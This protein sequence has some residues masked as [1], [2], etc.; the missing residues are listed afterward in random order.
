VSPARR[1]F[2]LGGAVVG[3]HLAFLLVSS[4]AIA[5]SFRVEDLPNG[6]VND[7]ANCHDDGPGNP[8]ND[9]GSDAQSA[10]DPS[11]PVTSA[12]VI[13]AELCPKDSDD[14]GWTNGEE[15]GDP[16]C[17]W[18][19]GDADPLGTVFNPGRASSHPPSECGNGRLEVDEDCEGSELR[20]T[21][22]ADEGAGDGMLGCVDC[23]YDY[24]GCSSPPA[25]ESTSSSSG[26]GSDGDSNLPSESSGSG[27]SMGTN[28]QFSSLYGVVALAAIALGRRRAASEQPRN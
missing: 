11:T 6:S 16:D 9:F 7:C 2:V 27:C 23:L 25:S 19:R 15:L 21:L 24:S 26:G 28:T 17:V 4:E 18:I 5:R 13:W 20:A 8:R 22:C 14:D 12:P 1:A 3:A 10:L